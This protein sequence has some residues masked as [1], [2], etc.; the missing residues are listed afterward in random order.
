MVGRTQFRLEWT[1]K[2][3]IKHHTLAN[4]EEMA[5]HKA[6]K[7]CEDPKIAIV[8]IY[9]MEHIDQLKCDLDLLMLDDE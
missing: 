7:I 1:N 3:G 5:R 6:I 9:K 8:N 2:H 4:T